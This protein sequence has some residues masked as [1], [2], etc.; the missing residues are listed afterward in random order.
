MILTLIAIGLFVIGLIIHILDVIVY[1]DIPKWLEEI[2]YVGLIVG[3][4]ISG[5]CG[6]IIFANTVKNDYNLQ[7]LEID[8]S[9][10]LQVLETGVYTDDINISDIQTIREVQEFN[11]DIQ[12]NQLYSKNVWINWFI[13]DYWNEIEQLDLTEYL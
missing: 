12:M 8:R 7:K 11:K 2:E 13:P 5:V 3:G 1:L 6:V 10:Y 9:N 4:F